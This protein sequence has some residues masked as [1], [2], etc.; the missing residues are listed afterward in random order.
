MQSTLDDWYRLVF[1]PLHCTICGKT[2][3]QEIIL[4]DHVDLVHVVTKQDPSHET[5]LKIKRK[6]HNNL[7]ELYMLKYFPSESCFG[8]E[9]AAVI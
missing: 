4:N 3:A 8:P 1:N 2:F 6:T 5:S 7:Q 9:E